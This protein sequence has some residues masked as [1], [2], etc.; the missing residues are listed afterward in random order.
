[1][2]AKLDRLSRDVAFVSA[3]MAQRVPFIVAELGPDVD[4]FMLHIY[5]ALAEKERRMISDRTMAAL[6]A[7]KARGVRL[8]N[9]ARAT[10]NRAQADAFAET[11][12]EVVTPLAF[13][14]RTTSAI[15]KALNARSIKTPRGGDW[16]PMQVMRLLSRLKLRSRD[17]EAG[18][19]NDRRG[20]SR[21][22]R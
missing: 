11:L 9:H 20:K 6:A 16:Q 13:A 8:G 4:P 14:S 18:G 5:A 22:P 2:V 7:A 15:A 12:R 10:A 3:L 1:V 17:A 19:R 21:P